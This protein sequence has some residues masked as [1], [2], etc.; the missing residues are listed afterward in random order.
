MEPCLHVLAYDEH[1]AGGSMIRAQAGILFDAAPE[2]AKHHDRDVVVTSDPL[3][4][5]LE[6]LQGLTQAS[7][8]IKAAGHLTRMSIETAQAHVVNP[9]RKAGMNKRRY[10]PQIES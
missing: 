5:L 1:G 6:R 10:F 3:Q 9:S 7:E 8:Q 2:L 4:I